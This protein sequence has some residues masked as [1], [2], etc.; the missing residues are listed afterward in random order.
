MDRNDQSQVDHSSGAG[1]AP[2]QTPRQAEHDGV[3]GKC[4]WKGIEK[5]CYLDET[6]PRSRKCIRI[7]CICGN[8]RATLLKTDVFQPPF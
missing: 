5:G 8:V 7:R 3:R 1:S 6:A 2:T 4:I